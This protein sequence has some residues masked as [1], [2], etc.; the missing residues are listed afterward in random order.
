MVTGLTPDIDVKIKIFFSF[1]FLME[2]LFA[3]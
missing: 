3:L 1:T 2:L